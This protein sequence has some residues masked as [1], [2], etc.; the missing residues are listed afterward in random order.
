MAKSFDFAKAGVG[1]WSRINALN[2]PW[3]L[4]DVTH[5]VAEVGNQ[6]GCHHGAESGGPLG[7]SLHGSAAGV[8]GSQAHVKRPILLHAILEIAQ[9]VANVEAIAG[10]SPR[11]HGICSPPR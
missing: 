5:L 1:Y 10:A 11:M 4:D 7:H 9:G 3:H 2:S 8:A 6:L